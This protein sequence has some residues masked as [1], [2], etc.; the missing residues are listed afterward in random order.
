MDK[1][2]Y[3]SFVIPLKDG[4]AA[5]SDPDVAKANGVDRPAEGAAAAEG[6][7]EKLIRDM[8]IIPLS[9]IRFSFQ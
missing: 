1:F 4:E 9:N 2:Q 8:K 3:V 7:S 6:R 5:K